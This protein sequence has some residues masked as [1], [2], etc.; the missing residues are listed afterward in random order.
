MPIVIQLIQTDLLPRCALD[1]SGT[2]RHRQHTDIWE[3]YICMR[4]T[5]GIKMYEGTHR[6]GVYGCKG[7]YKGH[8][9]VQG[10]IQMYGRCMDVWEIIW[11]PLNIQT[12]RH[13]PMCLPTT[14][15]GI[16]KKFSFP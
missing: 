6:W 1:Y 2:Y 12:D 11:T 7:V 15:E 4:H 8:T 3:M 9:D 13:T 14:P 10:D 5:G 16:C